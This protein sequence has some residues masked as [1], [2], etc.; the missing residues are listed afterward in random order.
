[1]SSAGSSFLYSGPRAS[2]AVSGSNNVYLTWW[3]N[4]TGNNEVFFAASNDGGKTFGKPINLSN[5]KGG[6]ADSQIAASGSNVYVTWWDNKT[7][8]WEVFSKA[9]TDNGKS[10]GNDSTVVIKS[11][12][13]SPV[14]G[15]K[16]PSSNTTS[17][18]TIVAASGNNE[19]VVWWDNTTGNWDV[20]FAKSTDNGKSFGSPIN[21]SNSPDSRSLGARMATTPQE[22]N[23]YIAWIDI[24]KDG[25]KQV[26]FRSSTDSGK[27]FGNAVMVNGNSTTTK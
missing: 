23:V 17:V 26:M 15:L 6:S 11:V 7:G 8:S 19:Y 16:A 25:Q 18:D 20:F 10:F 24:T 12:G 1:M 13:S 21:I 14:K 4:K 5:A 3:D 22:G 27:T 9:S 2:I